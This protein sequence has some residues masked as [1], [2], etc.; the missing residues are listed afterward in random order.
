[1]APDNTTRTRTL[2][3]TDLVRIRASTDE[4]KSTV[5]EWRGQVLS[6]QPGERPQV[7]F[8]IQGMSITRAK[9]LDNDS[10]DL[11]T[12][13]VQLYL[14]PTTSEV[15]HTWHNPWTGH[16]VTVVHVANNPVY[17]N[18]PASSA[19]EAH[20]QPGGTYTFHLSIPLA[21]PN[22]LNPTGDPAS[23]TA[24]YAGPQA[25]YSAIES[26][27]FTFPLAELDG[28]APSLPSMHV[29]W[30]R[31]SPLLP[32]MASPATGAALVCVANGA[33]V[34][35]GW[36]G[37]S[38]VLRDVV[39]ARLPAYKEAP[40]ERDRPGGGVSSWSYFAR[41]EVLRA[42]EDGARFPLLDPPVDAGA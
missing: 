20:A 4:S 10:Y 2:S 3:A 32:F 14:D 9:K 27:T 18:F 25:L 37:L 13:E 15:L 8:N 36:E 5:I 6:Y 40:T 30:T 21:Y 19:F 17:Q 35:R 33:K 24:P 11:L 1:M 22:P 34:E 41:P 29:H 16:D 38:P 28:P 42:Y 26:F 39:E 12:R 31:A 23:P 7:L